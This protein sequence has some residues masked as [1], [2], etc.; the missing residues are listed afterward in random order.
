MFAIFPYSSSIKKY[1]IGQKSL[2]KWRLMVAFQ[3][4][5]GKIVGNNCSNRVYQ[6]A[7]GNTGAFY[8]DNDGA[9]A[10]Q[11]HAFLMDQLLRLM[12]ETFVR[13]VYPMLTNRWRTGCTCCGGCG[14]WRIGTRKRCRFAFSSSL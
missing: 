5:R 14:A 10:V 4:V 3:K 7:C 8:R 6:T 1:L 13:Y 11:G 9:I 2:V 12:Y